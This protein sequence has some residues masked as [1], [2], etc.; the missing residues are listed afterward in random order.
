MSRDRGQDKR[1]LP[2]RSLEFAQIP[3]QV[4]KSGLVELNEAGR[5]GVI[6]SMLIF[7][8]GQAP[9]NGRHRFA[10]RPILVHDIDMAGFLFQ[11]YTQAYAYTMLKLH[12][13]L[14]FFHDLYVVN[15]N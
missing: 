15:Y 1:S 7:L 6:K 5:L 12:S 10:A 4:H 3:E 2:Q 9:V 8:A 13:G 14:V 11:Y